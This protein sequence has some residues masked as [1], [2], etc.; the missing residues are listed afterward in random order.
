M[1]GSTFYEEDYESFFWTASWWN[2]SDKYTRMTKTV[3]YHI[4]QSFPYSVALFIVNGSPADIA[5]YCFLLLSDW[6]R[7]SFVFDWEKRKFRQYMMTK[8]AF[9]LSIPTLTCIAGGFIFRLLI[10]LLKKSLHSNT[11]VNQ[12]KQAPNDI[13]SHLVLVL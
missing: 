7:V 5:F 10:L 11:K 12:S 8:S 13:T 1:K 4:R 2:S 6:T 9:H 3:K